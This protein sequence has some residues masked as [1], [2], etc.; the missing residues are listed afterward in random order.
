M[1]LS[2][3]ER[4]LTVLQTRTQKQAAV[5]LGVS[6]RT[7]RRWKNEG[8][9]PVEDNRRVLVKASGLA[10]RALI[11]RGEYEPK[12][13]VRLTDREKVTTILDAD[14]RKR[15]RHIV[16]KTRVI[17]PSQRQSR[18][19]PRTAHLNRKK[20]RYVPS[21]TV[22]FDVHKGT[23]ESITDLLEVYRPES[24]GFRLIYRAEYLPE[25]RGRGSPPH[26]PDEDEADLI[27]TK[28]NY[29]TNWRTLNSTFPAGR[30]HMAANLT[31]RAGIKEYV[32]AISLIGK[33]QYVVILDQIRFKENPKNRGR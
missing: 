25:E 23:V 4:I 5:Y 11:R 24:R 7:V 32:I 21:D 18:V 26:I 22:I 16:P 33:I 13:V 20:W 9:E 31:T 12:T 28:I 29:S 10:R 14:E 30:V 17:F 2:T 6:V 8:V 15:A 3:A 19:D 1:K 27:G